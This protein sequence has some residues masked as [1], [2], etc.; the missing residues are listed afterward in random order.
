MALFDA[1]RFFNQGLTLFVVVPL[2]VLLGLYLTWQLRFVQVNKLGLG[3]R[4]LLSRNDSTKEA[5]GNISHF[6]A[7]ASVLASNFG[8]GNISGMAV[9]IATGGPGALVWMW[10]MTFLGS[11]VQFANTLL[12]VKFRRKNGRG[13]FVGG[14]MYYLS[15][16]L[17]WKGA[18][19]CFSLCVIMAAV[20]VGDFVQVNSVALPLSEL[21]VPRIL[22]GIAIAILV[23]LVVIGG[24]TRVATVSSMVVP[25]MAFLYL[26]AALWILGLYYEQISTAVALIFKSSLGIAPIGGAGL[27]FALSKALSTGFDRAIF[28]TDAGTGTVPLLQSGARTHHPVIDGV[29]TLVAPFLVMI[30]CSATV[31]VLMV[32]GAFSDPALAS[33]SMVTKAFSRGLGD[34]GVV[35]VLIALFLFGYTTTLAWS[36]CLDRAVEYLFGD[37]WVHLFRYIFIFLVPVGAILEVGLVWTLA[38]IA[39]TL[40]LIINVLGVAA[41]S[42]QVTQDHRKFFFAK[43]D[44][45]VE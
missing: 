10:V 39:L 36:A 16:G 9:A 21:G 44:P 8:T 11:A 20:A 33:T 40:M 17:G 43:F 18:A 45:S 24:A 38:D 1:L 2:L 12:G 15:E 23:A 13:E 6:Q 7:V 34:F 19:L 27:G 42:R 32:T 4:H 25:L 37:R 22:S 29:V 26:G 30:V 14:P 3:F 41:L 35:V 5:E 28:A 31:L